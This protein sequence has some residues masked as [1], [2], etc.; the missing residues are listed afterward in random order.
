MKRTILAVLVAAITA[1]F[2]TAP[3]CGQAKP[4]ASPAAATQPAAPASQ[5]AAP[6][7]PLL[8]I[9]KAIAITGEAPL[10]MP[11]TIQ[12]GDNSPLVILSDS[13]MWKSPCALKIGGILMK[14]YKLGSVGIQPAN[15]SGVRFATAASRIPRTTYAGRILVVVINIGVDEVAAGLAKK[16]DPAA[17]ETYK[18]NLA[19]LLDAP[20]PANSKLI[21]LAPT[22]LDED[23]ASE[24]NARLAKYTEVAQK[25]A[26]GKNC[27]YVDLN[28]MFLN[29]LKHKPEG[30]K[31]R[32]LTADGGQVNE[33]GG[34]ILTLGLARALGMNDDNIVAADRP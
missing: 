23:P 26:A 9:E 33:L 27:T 11:K 21:L 1:A 32:F 31:E 25:L 12:L 20:R 15:I 7:K 19:K 17:L 30:A 29:A 3:L 4:A 28:R 8:P 24:G 18:A 2:C 13:V 10:D 16:F 14:Q 5:P 34:A 6:A 22:I